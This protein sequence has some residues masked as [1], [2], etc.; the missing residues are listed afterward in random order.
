MAR[1]TRILLS[2]LISASGL[3]ASVSAHAAQYAIDGFAIGQPIAS[4]NPNYRSYSCKPSEQFADAVD[5]KR[6]QQKNIG[7]R[8]V[9]ISNTLIHTRDG[10]AIYE[11]M[12][13]A[14]APMN[15]AAV[16]NEIS[17]LTRAIGE[18]AA[19]VDR[20]EPSQDVMAVVTATWER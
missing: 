9:T 13:V 10:V 19:S 7:G 17:D 14:P 8:P 15:N 6:T 20:Q 2:A 3:W 18:K 4:G 12:D 5:C 11:V 1:L 16:Q